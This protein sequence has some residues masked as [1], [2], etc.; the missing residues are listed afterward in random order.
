MPKL[1]LFFYKLDG[2]NF[3]YFILFYFIL[4]KP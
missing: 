1:N 4:L 3:I 2:F